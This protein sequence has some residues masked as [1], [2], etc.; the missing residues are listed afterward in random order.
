MSGQRL[1]EPD[2]HGPD[3]HHHD[4][5]HRGGVQG[6]MRSLL[7]PHSHDT[8]AAVDRALEAS[9]EGMRALKISLAGLA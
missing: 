9:E 6:W 2:G 4:H 8:S 7:A 1:D 3:D 5:D